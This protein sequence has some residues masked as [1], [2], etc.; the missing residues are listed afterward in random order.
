MID[1]T[2]YIWV[3]S[4]MKI[5]MLKLSAVIVWIKLHLI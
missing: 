2:I 1:T 4:A 3:L 5:I